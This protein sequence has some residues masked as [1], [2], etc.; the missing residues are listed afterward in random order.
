MAFSCLVLA[1]AC[2]NAPV[3][4]EGTLDFSQEVAVLLPPGHPGEAKGSTLVI[5]AEPDPP[6]IHY[7]NCFAGV[8]TE[9]DF[10]IGSAAGYTKDYIGSMVLPVN[11]NLG[12]SVM[13]YYRVRIEIGDTALQMLPESVAGS[14]S[15][16]STDDCTD[17]CNS[18]CADNPQYYPKQF[19][20]AAGFESPPTVT[21][22][23]GGAIVVEATDSDTSD[24]TTGTVNLCNVPVKIVGELPPA[25]GVTVSFTVESLQDPAG[26]ELSPI[27]PL[28]GIIIENIQLK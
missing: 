18:A 27:N 3:E 24:P 21:K 20:R 23:S 4:S 22:L 6:A 12:N 13:E 8:T 17:R 11:V 28:S 14:Y 16:L 1:G 2:Q 9:G 26:N 19:D 7:A 15:W 25:S 10:G 5:P